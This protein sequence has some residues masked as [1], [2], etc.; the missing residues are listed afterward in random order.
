M[1]RRY[2]DNHAIID[3][4]ASGSGMEVPEDV[5]RWVGSHFEDADKE[6]ALAILR[7]AHIHTGKPADPR[8]LRCAAVSSGG[9][10]RRLAELVEHLKVDSRDVILWAEYRLNGR[11][12]DGGSNYEKVHDFNKPI[13]DP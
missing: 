11:K 12:F 10:L 4:S 8:L 6:R 9:D 5:V 7:D 13:E 1:L 2:Y 3:K